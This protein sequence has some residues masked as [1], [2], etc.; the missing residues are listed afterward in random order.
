MLPLIYFQIMKRLNIYDFIEHTKQNKMKYI[1]YCE[2]IIDPFGK[3]IQ[4]IPSHTEA[5]LAY[6]MEKENKTRKE[7][8]ES[9]PKLCLPLEWCVDKYGLIAVWHCGYMY[10]TYKKS[11]NRFQRRSL[12]ILIKNGL[13]KEEHVQPASEY[14]LYLKRKAMG[15]E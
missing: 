14:T 12:D 8:V 9:I 3:V 1:N 7:L 15:I 6:V 2:I 13:V 10:S 11:P 5:A 4:S